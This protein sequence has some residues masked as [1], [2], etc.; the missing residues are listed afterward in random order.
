MDSTINPNPLKITSARAHPLVLAAAASVT[1]LGLAG[2]AYLAGWLPGPDKSAG[3]AGRAVI[4]ADAPDARPAQGPSP[5][6]A[7]AKPKSAPAAVK[8]AAQDRTPARP[9]RQIATAS[10]DRVR[11]DRDVTAV[12]APTYPVAATAPAICRECGTIESVREVPI[13][14]GGSG[15]GAVAGGIVGGILGNQL[16]RGTTRDIATVI[17]AIGGAYAGNHI[18]KS[19]KESKRYDVVVRFEDGSTRTFSGDAPSSWQVGDRVRLQNGTLING[20]GRSFSDRGTV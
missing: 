14:T 11:Q 15:T 7:V 8:S 18:E 4:A 2:A 9:I 13:E 20:G 10:D 3:G 12:P 17:G 1:V 19:M 6:L 16:G 5:R